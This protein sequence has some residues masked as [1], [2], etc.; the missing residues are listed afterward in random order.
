MCFCVYACI[1]SPLNE[2]G[3]LLVAVAQV[4]GHA[5]GRPAVSAVLFVR[6]RE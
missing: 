3:F 4:I 5:Y 6:L 2:S 1:T